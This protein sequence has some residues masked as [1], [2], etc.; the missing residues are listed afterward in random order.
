MNLYAQG[1][2]RVASPRGVYQ[3]PHELSQPGS[4]ADFQRA[5]EDML[6]V[7]LRCFDA[8][9]AAMPPGPEAA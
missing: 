7:S 9:A 6:V 8:P 5:V 3:N 4:V 1:K 2:G